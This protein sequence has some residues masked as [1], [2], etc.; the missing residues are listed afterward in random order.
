MLVERPERRGKQRKKRVKL[1]GVSLKPPQREREG[2]VERDT[3]SERE[4]DRD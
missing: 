2:D 3:E 1:Q 4:R